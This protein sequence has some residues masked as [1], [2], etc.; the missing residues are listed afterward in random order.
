MMK[1]NP[2]RLTIF[3]CLIAS[4]ILFANPS[5]AATTGIIQGTVRDTAGAPLKGAN[6]SLVGTGLVSVTDANGAYLFTGV[7]P[8]TYTIR[9]E[10]VTYQSADTTVVLQQDNTSTNDFSLVKKTVTTGTSRIVGTPVRRSD[11]TTQYTTT[12]RTEQMEKTNPNNLYQFTGLVWG[13]PGITQ[14][15][16]GFV[17]IRGADLNQAG[18]MVD[19]VP[20][21]DTTSNQFTTNTVSVGMRSFNLISGGADP[22]YGG[23]LGGFI[24]EVVANGKDF[25]NG[26]KLYGGHF[27]YTAGPGNGWDYVSTHNE[28]GGILPGGKLDYYLSTIMFKNYFP[29]NTSLSALDSSFDGVAKFNYYAG[30]KDTVT[31]FFGQGFEEYNAYQP[32]DPSVSPFETTHFTNGATSSVDTGVFQQDH[33]VQHY[34]FNYLSYKHGFTPKSFLTYRLYTITMPTEFHEENTSG[35]YEHTAPSQVGNQLDYTNQL[36]SNYRLR[37]GLLYLQ[38]K[39]N[40]ETIAS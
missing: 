6:V 8:G 21:M 4:L 36:S 24:N 18:F 16:A 27:E 1:A 3:F 9:T 37:A 35:V 17:H 23:A 31:A 30:S 38:Q 40:F 10:L 5:Y 34:Y 29:G 15:G 22:S 14:D 25:S 7:Q 2:I 32:F 13:Q 26:T 12:A 28:Y 19:G 39:N 33:Q 20:L 11:T